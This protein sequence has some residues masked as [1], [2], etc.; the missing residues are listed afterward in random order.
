MTAEDKDSAMS[1]LAL[2]SITGSNGVS[3]P[4]QILDIFDYA[5]RE[6]AMVMN[7]QSESL[8]ILRLVSGEAGSTFQ[9]IDSDEE[10]ENVLGHIQFLAKQNSD[11][12]FE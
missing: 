1:E 5:E 3:I 7:L 9:E 2:I 11:E 6:Y 12:E 10:Y 4:C 8:V